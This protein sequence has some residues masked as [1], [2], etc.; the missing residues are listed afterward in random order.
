MDGIISVQ[1]HDNV[2]VSWHKFLL[3]VA[4]CQ[5]HRMDIYVDPE[6][7][8]DVVDETLESSSSSSQQIFASEE[9]TVEDAE[10][11]STVRFLKS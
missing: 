4:Y 2:E 1:V 9:D 6:Q 8:E 10:L 5:L 11:K 7:W 3:Y